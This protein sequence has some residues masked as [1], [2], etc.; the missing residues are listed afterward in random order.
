MF[1]LEKAIEEWRK[2][3][4]AA[5]VKPPVPLEELESHLREEVA[6]QT[7]SGVKEPEAFHLAVLKIGQPGLLKREFAKVGGFYGFLSRRR[8]LKITLSVHGLL[9]LT[10]LICLLNHFGRSS[11][12][13]NGRSLL[14]WLIASTRISNGQ[15]LLVFLIFS[16]ALAGSVLLVFHS[17]WERSIIR[18][19]ALL[20]LSVWLIQDCLVAY[21]T[22]HSHGIEFTLSHRSFQ[23]YVAEQG[24]A[25]AFC[26]VSILILHLPEKANLKATVKL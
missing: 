20:S 12:I 3:M 2:Q 14:G 15:S 8:T 26:L 5:G 4:V 24:L 6:Q 25:F 18:T 22:S 1:N 21:V 19:I 17:K 23:S 13:Y 16:A 11:P 10:W 7:K 9:G